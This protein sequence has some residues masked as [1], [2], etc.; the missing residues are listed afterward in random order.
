MEKQ[1][2][3]YQTP[4]SEISAGS[5]PSDLADRLTRLGASFIDGMIMLALLLPAM[6]LSGYF[7]MVTEVARAGGAVPF[8]TTL[9]WSVLGYGAFILVQGWPLNASGQTWGKRLLQIKVVTL[10][11]KKP[12]LSEL[13]LKRY[14]PMQVAGLVPF[15]GNL[16]MAVD[17]LMIF[18]EDRRCLHDLLAGT[19][20]VI[21]K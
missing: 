19:R 21:A 9:F 13:L 3:P 11:G 20:V 15:V 14:L 12:S 10:E 4:N 16:Y 5:E 7:R 6:Y 17:T 2:N 18:R 8:G 1:K